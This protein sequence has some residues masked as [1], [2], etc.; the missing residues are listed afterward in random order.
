M[1][2][3]GNDLATIKPGSAHVSITSHARVLTP[4]VAGGVAYFRCSS[5][6]AAEGRMTLTGGHGAGWTLG[7]IQVEHV[8][9]NWLFYRGQ[10]EK[11]GS[12]FFQ[13]SRPPA[14]PVKVCRDVFQ[15]TDVFYTRPWDLA[16]AQD[17]DAY[18]LLLTAPHY[19]K[20]SDGC[21]IQMTNSKTGKPNF[22]EEVQLEFLFCTVLT[23]LAPSGRYH[24]LK[25]FYWNV[26]WQARFQPLAATHPTT[27]AWKVTPVA[28]G[29]GQ[30][31][32][33]VFDG[34]PDD[35]RFKGKMTNTAV[36]GCNAIIP[37]YTIMPAGHPCRRESTGWTLPDVRR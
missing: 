27:G 3:R 20:P 19:D 16:K 30:M 9:T 4:S 28:N 5:N 21:A 14:R 2:H 7:F 8:D 33:R 31:T 24:F 23:A 10:H 12:I 25:N 1:P 18:P 11:D 35:P 26:R 13:R 34:E 37:N 22:L 32:S 17:M 15:P 36:P 6:I 29:C